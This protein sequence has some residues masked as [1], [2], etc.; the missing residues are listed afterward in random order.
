VPPSCGGSVPSEHRTLIPALAALAHKRLLFFAGKGGVGKTTVAATVAFTL[1]RHGKKTLLIELDDSARA[2]RLLGVPTTDE[3]ATGPRLVSPSLFVLSTS[4]QL[5]LEEYLRLIIPFKPLLRTIVESRAYQ[6]FV[7]A[8][9]GLKELLT[10]G[11]VW[12][13][14][15]KREAEQPLWDVIVIDLPATGHSLQYLR[16][17]RAAHETFGGIISREAE[18]IAAVL[19]DPEKT[20]VNLV[21]TPD[22]LPV[23]ETHDAYRQLTEEL[24]LPMGALFINRM[25]TAPLS[26]AALHSTTLQGTL[27]AKD[28][29][30]LELLLRCG[31]TEAV[32]TDIQTARLQ[33]LQSLPIP[34]IPIPFVVAEAGDETLVAQLSRELTTAVPE[35]APRS[36]KS[37]SPRSRA[38]RTSRVETSHVKSEE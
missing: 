8:A 33:S 35:P 7:A 26:A 10:I 29:Q 21:T 23:S 27:S 4:G 19:H 13:E 15:R 37:G 31:H 34:R 20:A 22:E 18:R 5:A 2:S 16:M 17:P 9:P 12:Y 3:P 11:K 30:F 38:P 36:R 24:R 28:R 14:E 1:A 6:Y 25:R 32:E